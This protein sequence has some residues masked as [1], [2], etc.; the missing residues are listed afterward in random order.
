[1]L[2]RVLENLLPVRPGERRLTF[3][4]FLHSF[5][6]VGAFLSGRSVRDALFLAHADRAALASMYIVS[7]I[8]VAVSGLAYGAAA[9]RVRRDRMALGSAAAFAALFIGFFALDRLQATWVYAGLYVF[10]EVM[11]ALSLVQF[12]TLAN[13]L[14]NAREAKRLY[15]VIGSGAMIA[16][17]L[18]GY[19][20]GAMAAR[21]GA[22][23]VLLLCAALLVGAAAASFAAG[24]YGRHRLF[25]RALSPRS[26]TRAA[27]PWEQVLGSGHLRAVAALSAITFFT[28]TLVDY[29]FKVFAAQAYPK[30]Q[31]AAY[32][33]YFYSAVGVLALAMQLFGTG[34]ILGKAGVIASLA[35]LPAG[36]FGGNI[37][38]ALAPALWSATLVKGA[39]TLLR[40]TVND[41]TTQILYLP[42][43][44]GLRVSAKAF[45]DG[46][47]KPASIALAGLGLVV[48]AKYVN[49]A[50]HLAYPGLVLTAAWIALVLGL[51]THYLKSLQENLRRRK[52]DL[53]SARHRVR[54][55]ST[56]RV[57]VRALES[58]D[59][60]EVLSALRLLPELEDLQLDHRVEKLLDHAD[61]DVRIAA[62]RYYGR[63]GTVRFANSVF[64]RF[65]DP[66][67]EVRAAAI[68][69]FC[70]LGRDKAVRSVRPFL[71]DADP[72]VRSAAMVGM[73]RFGGLDGVLVAAEALK[74]LI[75]DHDE[76]M[77]E[78]AAK[79]LGEIGVKNFYQPV[80]ELMS[81]AQPTVRRRAIEA[82]GKLQ[83]P[84]FCIPLIYQTRSREL[85]RE[86]VDALAAYGTGIL[87]TLTK[88]L[89][90]RLEDVN[91][92]RS[93]ARVLARIGGPEVVAVLCQHLDDPDDELRQRLYR[94]LGRA[95]KAGAGLGK[96]R[97]Q[98]D[99]A[100]ELEL[101]RAYRALWAMEV[102][103]LTQ[104]P[105]AQTSHRSV[106][107]AAALL[108]SALSE[109][110]LLA[111]QRIFLLI[112][113]LHP[114]ADI[115]AIVGSLRPP[116]TPE[117]TRRRSNA[118]ELLDN[119]LPRELKERFLPLLDDAPRADKLRAVQGLLDFPRPEAEAALVALCHE[120]NP[121]MRACAL[122]YAAASRCQP[123]RNAIIAA[124]GDANAIVREVALLGCLTAAP[125][126]V[127]SLATQ[128]LSD[129]APVVRR[130][131][132][133]LCREGD[134]KAGARR[135]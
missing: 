106:Q 131:A 72:A 99:T 52:L 115:E 89:G 98:V 24:R 128:R 84:E 87:G 23:A 127:R 41:A 107:G 71:K 94:A 39:D 120:D 133:R 5:F 63:R 70:A 96:H 65:D 9:T 69:A 19:A 21:L 134:S 118:L 13:E 85:R 3:A 2:R 110:I 11:G 22:S 123:A 31:L 77:R 61:A 113:A 20:T 67:P 29:E 132:E 28:T 125:E 42:V 16:N 76:V 36:L 38:L 95:V 73:I 126:Q 122:H 80:L 56:Q 47:V 111:E 116:S 54:D 33:G 51:R 45:V 114:D 105:S 14:F 104:A 81:D 82:A 60:R 49:D 59:A 88:V 109:Q 83:S 90:N 75:T 10:V 121:W 108:C 79:V 129:E 78:H 15:G 8:A 17:I 7:A 101:M 1:V 6:A 44:P 92:R 117:E 93:I 34:R 25:A 57:F 43:A 48:Y 130:Q 64:R 74:G 102:L 103:G 46:V 119:L 135:L 53:E 50:R 4:L 12:W 86:A 27:R 30:D 58:D 100:L 91:I 55:G 18:A 32:F 62:L 66:K 37:A 26:N 40:Y 112:G 35:L 68:D 124:G 97:P